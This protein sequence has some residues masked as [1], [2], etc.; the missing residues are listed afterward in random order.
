[1]KSIKYIALGLAVLCM[2]FAFAACGR[3]GAPVDNAD[4]LF[5]K[6]C[7]QYVGAL[8]KADADLSLDFS[9]A[10]G[11]QEKLVSAQKNFLNV[12]KPAYEELKAI[13]PNKLSA[14]NKAEAEEHLANLEIKVDTFEKNLEVL[15]NKNNE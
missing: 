15:E 5:E 1:M 2:A 6:W 12:I 9:L 10:E 8:K 14:A 7:D 13:D 3:G 4:T 11:D